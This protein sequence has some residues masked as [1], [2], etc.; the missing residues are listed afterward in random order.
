MQKKLDV[1]PLVLDAQY[2]D[3]LWNF[4]DSHHDLSYDLEM[5]R[6]RDQ[7]VFWH[8]LVYACLWKILYGLPVKKKQFLVSADPS[9]HILWRNE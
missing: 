8:Y 6:T 3:Y 9:A 1:E 4:L 7:F 5:K 2:P